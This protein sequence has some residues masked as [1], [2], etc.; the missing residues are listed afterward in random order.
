[1]GTFGSLSIRQFGPDPAHGRG[2]S[3][4]GA[5][6]DGGRTPQGNA[7]GASS[8]R[9]RGRAPDGHHATRLVRRADGRCADRTP[10]QR[11]GHPRT[12]EVLHRRGTVGA[13]P[14]CRRQG[15]GQGEVRRRHR[16]AGCAAR[17][18]RA[19]AR[20]RRHDHGRR[21][22]SRRARPGRAGRARRRP[23]GRAACPSR[24]SGP[25]AGP[26]Q[27]DV[28]AFA[29]HARR[30]D[31]LRSSVPQRPGRPD[32]GPGRARWPRVNAWPSRFTSGPI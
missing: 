11:A 2:R 17:A 14:R 18:D 32:R 7:G 20:P 23:R 9:R 28:H 12:G 16:A 15:D 1:M 3:P 19:P 5:D 6:R 4:R 25:R 21:H 8:R 30:A 26:R 22:V 24:R 31:H 29:E 27:G 13:A 10:A